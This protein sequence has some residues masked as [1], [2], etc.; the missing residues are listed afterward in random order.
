MHIISSTPVLWL[1]ILTKWET[2]DYILSIS[3][4]VSVETTTL[5]ENFPFL[6]CSWNGNL[7]WNEGVEI[8]RR[9]KKMHEKRFIEVEK[10]AILVD[11]VAL[12]LNEI[13]FPTYSTYHVNIRRIKHV[14]IYWNKEDTHIYNIVHFYTSSHGIF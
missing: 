9:E 7:K 12:K 11:G 4:S 10:H 5:R 6:Q 3:I 1:F 13:C 8:E 14:Q 2:F